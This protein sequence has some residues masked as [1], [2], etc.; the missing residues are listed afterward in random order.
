M[1][2]C[3]VVVFVFVSVV[4][5]SVVVVFVVFVVVD[6]ALTVKKASAEADRVEFGDE[7]TENPP[8][9]RQFGLSGRGRI[10]P[11]TILIWRFHGGQMSIF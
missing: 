4:F 10:G 3:F 5:V 9:R 6:M 7:T 11:G 8:L 2:I 1:G